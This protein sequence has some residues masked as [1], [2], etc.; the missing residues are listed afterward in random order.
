MQHLFEQSPEI[1]GRDPIDSAVALPQPGWVARLGSLVR[2]H[3]ALGLA[4]AVAPAVVFV[5]LGVLLGP[6]VLNVLTPTVLVHLDVAVTVGLATLGVFVG[7]ALVG[8][9]REG[10][11]FVAASIE[12]LVTLAFV[13]A[14][15]AYLLW[16]WEMPLSLPAGLVAVVLGVSAAA[17][18]ASAA[19]GGDALLHR[20]ATRIADLDDALPILAGGAALVALGWPELRSVSEVAQ[21][22][23]VTCALGVAVAVVGWLLLD[24]EPSGP[25]R[26]L[27][28]VG[29]FLMLGGA[30][31]Y[32]SLSP[33]LAGV[34]A[35][36]CWQLMPGPTSQVVRLNLNKFQHPIVALLLIVAG[37]HC[38]LTLPALWIFGP[39]VL[40]RLAG[41]L[42]GGWVASRLHPAVT[43]A[44]LG[45][46]LVAPGLVGIAYALNVFQ[47]VPGTGGSE[48]L[49]ATVAATLASEALAIFL[50]PTPAPV[51]KLRPAAGEAS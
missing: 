41:K 25:E 42:A 32:L 2:R 22:T 11:L 33:L 49:T 14:A 27:F 9:E 48:I 29:T 23:G 35:G 12:A 5:P 37:A 20:T 19:S 39:L 31:A 4:P 16:R 45:S 18:S 1:G 47:V 36:L 38:E 7:M 46:Y 6:Y 26:G 3:A 43:G 13:A 30:A 34:S 44:D 8:G 51:E 15:M 50:H 24:R 40:F 28:V 10:R 17:S 21:W